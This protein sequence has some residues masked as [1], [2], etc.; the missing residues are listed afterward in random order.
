MH[1]VFGPDADSD[2]EGAGNQVMSNAHSCASCARRCV[3]S[4]YF[5]NVALDCSWFRVAGHRCY[6]GR[7]SGG[8]Q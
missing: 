2:A 1:D 4:F 5:L 6:W 8:E 7:A 3:S